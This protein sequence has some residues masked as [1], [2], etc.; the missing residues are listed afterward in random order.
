MA[1]NPPNGSSISTTGGAPSYVRTQSTVRT[2]KCLTIIDTEVDY[3]T[4]LNN[5]ALIYFAVF[6]GLLSY[7]ASLWI[8][9][10]FV[11][12]RTPLQSLLH[13]YATPVL[14]VLAIV[15]AAL[16]TVEL[17]RRR[18]LLDKIRSETRILPMS[19]ED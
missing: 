19:D 13:D 4:S 8:E 15:F 12:E 7:G 18:N 9:T 17:R 16:G 6:S 11:I 14:A 1:N 10:H 5:R 2:M 3:I